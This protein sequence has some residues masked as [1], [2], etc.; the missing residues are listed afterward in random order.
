MP[1]CFGDP[2]EVSP[3]GK[4][5]F[6]E[7]QQKCLVCRHLKPCL[8][9]AWAKRHPADDTKFTVDENRTITKITRFC[10]RWSRLKLDQSGH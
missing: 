5:G 4:E 3:L 9:A 2:D 8:R 10:K 7:P 6:P 1:E